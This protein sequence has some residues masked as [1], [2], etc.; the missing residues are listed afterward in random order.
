MHNLLQYVNTPLT[1]NRIP[2]K[3]SSFSITFGRNS[4]QGK[5]DNLMLTLWISIASA[6]R[7]SFERIHLSQ[8]L[9]S[10][11]FLNEFARPSSLSF[12]LILVVTWEQY[13]GLIEAWS[14]YARLNESTIF[15]QML[16]E[17]L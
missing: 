14:L 15:V 5:T 4:L 16:H 17:H 3:P 6:S 12:C 1:E 9:Q 8:E 13:T 7:R 11:K 10:E 2:L